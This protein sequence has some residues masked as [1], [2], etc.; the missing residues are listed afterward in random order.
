MFLQIVVI[1]KSLTPCFS[2]DFFLIIFMCVYIYLYVIIISM[3][4]L[5]EIG[6]F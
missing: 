1:V 2:L 5:A 3:C 4:A 6:G